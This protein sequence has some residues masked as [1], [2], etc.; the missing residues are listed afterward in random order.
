MIKK[1]FLTGLVLLL[2]VAVT[3]LII[4][5]L[6]DLFTTPFVPIVSLIMHKLEL[7]LNFQIP[8]ELT[9]PVARVLALILLIIFIHLLG[10]LTRWF[11]IKKT[12]AL[13]D[14]LIEKIPLV[15]S[16]YRTAQDIF[17]AIF[18]DDGKKAFKATV[19]FPFPFSPS[20]GVGFHVGDMCQEVQSKV[21]KPLIAVFVP[22][23]PHPISGFLFFVPKEKTHEI[24]M[25]IEDSLKFLISCGMISKHEHTK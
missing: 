19:M 24:D 21:D 14:K 2:P 13:T 5:F 3:V 16:I 7:A 15:K 9:L 12:L 6:V 1:Y 18:S 22:T 20:H 4:L 8:D 25:S 17:R 11:I 23:S 10:A